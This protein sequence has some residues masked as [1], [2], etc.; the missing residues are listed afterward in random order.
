MLDKLTQ[1]DFAKHLNQCFRI[2]SDAGDLQLELIE[3]TAIGT[4]GTPPDGKRW[5]NGSPEAQAS[6]TTAW[7]CAVLAA[8]V[9]PWSR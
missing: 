2:R 1:E 9:N 5:K 8:V 6:S 7:K 4:T 3:A